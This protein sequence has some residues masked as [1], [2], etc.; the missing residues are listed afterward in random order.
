MYSNCPNSFLLYSSTS[1]CH[2]SNPQEV[3][4]IPDL[5]HVCFL[6]FLESNVRVLSKGTWNSVLHCL[7]AAT[8]TL[9]VQSKT[10][11]DVEKIRMYVVAK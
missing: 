5:T 7:S 9:I 6:F 3:E 2:R 4:V 8:K 10:S 11:A 1:V